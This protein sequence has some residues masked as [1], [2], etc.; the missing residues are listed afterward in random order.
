MK[1]GL[2][3]LGVW[4]GYFKFLRH[5]GHNLGFWVYVNSFFGTGLAK[6][7]VKLGHSSTKVI[8]KF[9]GNWLKMK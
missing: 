7:G 4:S 2:G 9:F 1:H 8:F 3:I 5:L 6:S